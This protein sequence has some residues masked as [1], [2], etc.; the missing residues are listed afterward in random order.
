MADRNDS[1]LIPNKHTTY[2]NLT[3]NPEKHRRDVKKKIFPRESF[4]KPSV[5]PIEVDIVSRIQL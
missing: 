4:P 3:R 2:N 5:K 1:A